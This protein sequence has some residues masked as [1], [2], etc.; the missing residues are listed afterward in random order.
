MD[1]AVDDWGF[2]PQKIS[3]F[4]DTKDRPVDD[5]DNKMED[6]RY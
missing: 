1:N 5:N 4:G 6:W 3:I 2:L